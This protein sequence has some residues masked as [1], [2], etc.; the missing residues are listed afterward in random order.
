MTNQV[1]F[2]TYFGTQ[3]QGMWITWGNDESAG[4]TDL[5]LSIQMNFYNM[6]DLN[7]V[8]MN[9]NSINYM[10]FYLM[11][12][13]YDTATIG[14]LPYD[15]YV[16]LLQFTGTINAG[17]SDTITWSNSAQSWIVDWYGDASGTL[18]A[19][20]TSGLSSW[21]GTTVQTG[22]SCDVE[23]TYDES[24]TQCAQITVTL[25]RTLAADSGD[26]GVEDIDID[27]RKI[28]VKAGWNLL[29]STADQTNTADIIS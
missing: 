12:L 5:T 6:V 4:D 24:S 10:M 2:D 1:A 11:F 7:S 9:S 3:I 25:Q 16:G 15:A 14:T 18:V 28:Q 27:Y 29:D 19:P 20:D 21:D 23:I 17:S 22:E 13:N 26:L 8:N